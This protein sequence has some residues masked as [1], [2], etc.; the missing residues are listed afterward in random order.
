MR[1]ALASLV[2]LLTACDGGPPPAASAQPPRTSTIV[3][4]PQAIRTAYLPSLDPHTMVEAEVARVV[5]S[6]RRCAFHYTDGGKPVVA[7]V[8]GA[9]GVLKLNG[10]LVRLSA[11]GVTPEGGGVLRAE[12]LRVALAPDTPEDNASGRSKRAADMRFAVQGGLEVGYRGFFD[13]G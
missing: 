6:G 8:P 9:V 4:A 3:P 13:C 5:A 11:E 2:L 12:A 7:F 1:T 10:S